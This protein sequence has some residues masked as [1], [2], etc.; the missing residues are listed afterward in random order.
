MGLGWAKVGLWAAWWRLGEREGPAWE[1][2]GDRGKAWERHRGRDWKGCKREG[3]E[4]ARYR[5]KLTG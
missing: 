3:S 4:W 5:R 2:T 1:S